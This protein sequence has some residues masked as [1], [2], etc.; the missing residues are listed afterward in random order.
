MA[1]STLA[2]WPS[3]KGVVFAGSMGDP[4]FSGGAGSST[5][6]TMLALDASS[7]K[8][9]W[10]YPAG[11]SVIAGAIVS[12]DSVYWGSGY[13]HLGIPGFTGNNKFYAFSRNGN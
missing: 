13:A 7:G 5:A 8:T 6:P 4:T 10:S 9:L 3:A 2:P 1:P 12:G 11:S